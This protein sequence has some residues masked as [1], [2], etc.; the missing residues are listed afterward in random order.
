MQFIDVPA[1]Q[2]TRVP[3]QPEGR[4]ARAAPEDPFVGDSPAPGTMLIA[5]DIAPAPLFCVLRR[6]PELVAARFDAPGAAAE[7]RVPPR[8]ARRLGELC[9]RD[10]PDAGWRADVAGVAWIVA[11]GV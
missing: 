11:A 3:V 9:C 1:V 10:R 7:A 5:A 6:S 2:A 8:P 4:T